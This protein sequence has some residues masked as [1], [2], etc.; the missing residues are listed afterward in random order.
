MVFRLNQHGEYLGLGG[1]R[2]IFFVGWRGC[3]RSA[4]GPVPLF[5]TPFQPWL[6]FSQSRQIV[7]TGSMADHPPHGGK[8]PQS[9]WR[10]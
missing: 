4:L 10:W 7:F 5:D 3:I 8:I 6:N 1:R 2:L 9:A